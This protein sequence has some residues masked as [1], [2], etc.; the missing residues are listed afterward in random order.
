MDKDLLH[1]LLYNSIIKCNGVKERELS[2]HVPFQY[3]NRPNWVNH[4]GDLTNSTS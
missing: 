1:F 3:S 4:Q 2:K